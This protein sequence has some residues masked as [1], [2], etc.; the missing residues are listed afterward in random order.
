[1][2]E[3]DFVKL[4]GSLVTGVSRSASSR[5]RLARLVAAVHSL[6]RVCIAEGIEAE[7]DLEFVREIG[8]RLGQGFLLGNPRRVSQT[9]V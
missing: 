4:S 3:P 5:R 2:L 9:H 6:R 8:V 1:M 7:P